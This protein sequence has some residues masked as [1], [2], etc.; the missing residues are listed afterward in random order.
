MKFS[1]ALEE[2]LNGNHI[3]RIGWNGAGQF[4][5]LE[6]RLSGYKPVFVIRNAQGEFQPGWLPSM[7][8]LLADDWETC[9]QLPVG[10]T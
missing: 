5:Y 1:A 8:D 7:G 4:V 10:L 9:V 6:T 3:R 2:V